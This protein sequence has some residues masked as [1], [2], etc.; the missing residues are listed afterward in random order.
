MTK[1]L[2]PGARKKPRFGGNVL[3]FSG[4]FSGFWDFG[5]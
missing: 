1:D 4:F 3:G 5:V 2:V